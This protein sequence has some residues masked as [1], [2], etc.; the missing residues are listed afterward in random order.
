[1]K[2]LD[3]KIIAAL[4]PIF[5]CFL[6][7]LVFTF[8]LEGWHFVFTGRPRSLWIGPGGL[9][10]S[11][12]VGGVLGWLSYRHRHREFG[13]VEPFAHDEATSLLWSK[14]L[15]VLGACLAALYFIWQLAKSLR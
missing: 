15:I 7:F 9:L 14:R 6:G 8:G 1:M 3:K 13:G 4:F 11:L 5:G 10:L 2:D 12:V